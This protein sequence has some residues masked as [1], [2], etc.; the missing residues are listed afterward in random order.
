MRFVTFLSKNKLIKTKY[1][2]VTSFQHHLERNHVFVCKA[3]QRNFNAN[4]LLHFIC[5]KVRKLSHKLDMF[6]FR[7]QL[8]N[9][10]DHNFCLSCSHQKILP[11]FSLLYEVR[12][13]KAHHVYSINLC[14]IP[15]H[16]TDRVIKHF[17]HT[18]HVPHVTQIYFI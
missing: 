1:S 10:Y 6:D 9:N 5:V 15:E 2:V 12:I 14:L 3:V 17:T 13:V 16:T 11:S 18:R 8:V 7:Q 4:D